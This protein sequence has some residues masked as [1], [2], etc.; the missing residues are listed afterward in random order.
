[1]QDV[2]HHIVQ[3][4][5]EYRDARAVEP[6]LALLERAETFRSRDGE[7]RD[8]LTPPDA[9]NG[10]DTL[11]DQAAE[12]LAKIGD[13]RA[14][15]ALRKLLPQQRPRIIEALG[16]LHDRESVPQF[17]AAL[18]PPRPW[19]ENRI[20]LATSAA[21]ALAQTSDERA[22]PALIKAIASTAIVFDHRR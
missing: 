7:P 15:P 17:I 22:L 4:L 12:A 3:A 2:L 9:R 11:R 16:E 21:R 13:A 19:T 6:L 14:I 18:N 10:D 8:K 1:D 20:T 5:A